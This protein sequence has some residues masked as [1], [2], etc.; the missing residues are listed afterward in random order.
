MIYKR[1]WIS[2]DKHHNQFDKFIHVFIIAVS[3]VLFELINDKCLIKPDRESGK[4][5]SGKLFRVS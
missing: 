5:E 1:K 3:D 4:S 2:V